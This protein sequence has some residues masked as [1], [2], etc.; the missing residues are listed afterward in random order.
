MDAGRREKLLGDGRGMG[1]GWRYGFETRSIG[2]MIWICTCRDVVG[3]AD[4]LCL[5]D[6]KKER[7]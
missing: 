3:S 5:G 7:G 6:E 4:F 1:W 2:L